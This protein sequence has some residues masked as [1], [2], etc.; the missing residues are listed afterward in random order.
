MYFKDF[1]SGAMIEN[2]VRRAK[3]LAIKRDGGVSPSRV[4]NATIDV[5]WMRAND[6]FVPRQSPS[7][8]RR[9]T[10]AR[11]VVGAKNT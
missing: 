3:K 7:S 8:R 10:N 6:G 9:I 2:I 4:W 5:A 11:A 1:S